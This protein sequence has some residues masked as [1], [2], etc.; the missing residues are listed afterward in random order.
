VPLPLSVGV[1]F[2][3]PAYL[4]L[5]LLAIP[6]AWIG[7]RWFASMSRIRRWSAVILR[8]I[9]IALLTS[10]LAGAA[11]VRRTEKLAVVGVVDVSGSVRLFGDA[12][13]VENGARQDP[14]EAARAFFAEATRSR[15]PDDLFGLV[16]FDGRALAVATPT[17]GDPL[18]R[19]LDVQMTEGTNI[20]AA[21][22]TAAALIPPDAAGRI[23][24][25]SDGVETAGDALAAAAELAARAGGLGSRGGIPV[26]VIPVPLNI[27]REVMM[28]GVDAPP[29]AA[30]E[31]TITVRVSLRA[32]DAAS[33]TLLLLRDGEPLDISPQEPG[34]GRRLALE[35]GPHVELISIPL[36]EGKIHKFE[37]VFEPD[38]EQTPGGV[39]L[40]G[41]TRLENNRGATFTLTPGRGSIL[42]VD[43]I[44][45]GSGTPLAQLLRSG[46]LDV[47]VVPPEGIPGD[48]LSLQEYDLIILENTPAETVPLATQ[49]ALAAHVR[50]L[51]AGLVMVGGRDSFGAGGWKGSEIEPLLP[52][53]LDLPE[54]LIQPDA[55]VVLVLDNSG[56]M[57]RSVFASAKT[58]QQIANEAA[59]LA[60]RSLD[61]KDLVSIIVFNNET[62]VLVPLSPNDSPEATAERILSI[63]PG[64]G[65][66][67]GPALEAAR[68]QLRG[69]KATI[70][71]VVVLS[72]GASTGRETLPA[73]AARM[74][75]EGITVSTIGIGDQ[76][77]EQTMAAMAGHGGGEFYAVNNPNLLPR[78]F[79]RAVRV[80]RQPMIREGRFEPAIL[81]TPSPLTAGLSEAPPLFGLVLT[82][83]RPEPTIIYAIAATETEPLLAHWAVGLGQVAAWTSDASDWARDWLDHPAYSQLWMQVARTIARPAMGGN[84]ELTTE[85]AGDQL[86]IR[87]DAADDSGRPL[88]LLTVPA[89][90]YPPGGGEPLRLTLSQTGPGTYEAQAP[91]LESGTYVV[92]AQPRQGSQSLPPVFGGASRAAG[93]E[94]RR[95][96]ASPA[97]LER[98]A[99]L[100]GGRT[101]AL[102]AATASNLFD[103][104]G[105]VPTEARSPL[106]RPLLLWTLLVLLLD[107]ATRRVAWD[108]FVSREFG[109]ELRKSAAEA[110]RDRSEQASR[111]IEGLRGGIRRPETPP[112]MAL[113]D[114]DAQRIAEAEAQRRRENRLA[115]MAALRK[116]QADDRRAAAIDPIRPPSRSA[117]PATTGEPSR[118]GDRVAP[119]E[120]GTEGLLAAKRRA[121]ERLDQDPQ[122]A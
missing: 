78:F 116:A 82:Q 23:V 103:R 104:R 66:V 113:S 55:A 67:L 13:L 75:E 76:M 41:D 118:E 14:V 56:S 33:G 2:E 92:T 72:D 64:G 70:K 102:S 105:I 16:V 3:Q 4:S 54:Q 120:P 93:V 38:M 31:S 117:P 18:D 90:I 48:L 15:G 97:L 95:L 89:T 111:T 8:T 101:L 59:A 17:R 50:D 71:H 45:G 109:V 25:F 21:L 74:R 58:Q 86:R 69:V 46:N 6:V 85:V 34:F 36:P 63:G 114:E 100:T 98:I 96:E 84:S 83:P 24:L 115:A 32:T 44:S 80:I 29:R 73:L 99:A 49:Q 51:G 53:K 20:A 61:K 39:R 43:G 11:A 52:V 106:W 37:A 121:R 110:I 22:R 28:E 40:V 30:S 7:V 88:D 5:L 57:A 9:L 107:V 108:R 1:T 35:P 87:L 91:A 10:M 77:D 68:Q 60:I 94:F 65:T 12:G 26:D 119:V 122:D 27:S 81:P 79:L 19:A 62:T 47:T 112:A 42:L